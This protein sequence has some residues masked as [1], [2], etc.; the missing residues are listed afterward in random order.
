MR[1]KKL[2]LL[3]ILF[4]LLLSVAC[5]KG[6]NTKTEAV[7]TIVFKHGKIAGDAALFNKLIKRFEDKNPVTAGYWKALLKLQIITTT[8][9]MGI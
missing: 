9:T 4:I 3:F 5:A 2:S 6:D 1:N 7:T 8:R